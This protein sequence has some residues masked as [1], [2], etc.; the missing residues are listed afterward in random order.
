EKELEDK[1]QTLASDVSLLYK[2]MAPESFYNQHDRFS[3][4][5]AH[6]PALPIPLAKHA[7]PFGKLFNR[8]RVGFPP[9]EVVE[10]C[11]A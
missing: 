11:K 10:D 6:S 4:S 5:L 3:P 9:K 7:L 2:R 1:L 8:A